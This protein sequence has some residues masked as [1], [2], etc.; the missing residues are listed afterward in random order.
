MIGKGGFGKVWK[1]KFKKIKKLF[2]LK[3]M[4][5]V[6]IIDRRSEISIIN[7]RNFL[8]KLN[9]PFIVNMYFAF[10]DFSNLYLVMDLLTGGDLRYQIVRH[11]TFNEIQ[12]KFFLANIILGLEYIHSKNIIHRDIK[13]EN[14]VMES[15]GYIRITDFGVAKIN[16]KD[17]SS[18]TSGTPGYMAPEVLFVQNHSFPCDFFAIGVIGFEFMLGVRPYLGR[19]RQEI[20]EVVFNFQA[21]IYDEDIPEN[22]S[23][24]SVDFIN[25]L[26]LRKPNKRL[27]Y[28]NGVNELKNHNWFK[29]IDWE[30]LEKKEVE[31]PFLPDKNSENFDKEYCEEIDNV[32]EETIERYRQYIADELFPDVFKGYTFCNSN[33][34]EQLLMERHKQFKI[35]NKNIKKEYISKT[36]FINNSSSN[37]N[38]SHSN[39]IN[40]ENIFKNY[41]NIK[42]HKNLSNSPSNIRK[43]N[44]LNI[45]INNNNNL[46]KNKN[47][48]KSERNLQSKKNI[49]KE[50]ALSYNKINKNIYNNN[51]NNNNNIQYKLELNKKIKKSSSLKE[52]K[53][54][55]LLNKNLTTIKNKNNIN[56]N[57]TI[58]KP[59]IIEINI[60]NIKKGQQL[61]EELM[62]KPNKIKNKKINNFKKLT[63]IQNEKTIIENRFNK[64]E[65]MKIEKKLFDNNNN[66]SKKNNTNT[67]N[68]Y[69]NLKLYNSNSQINFTSKIMSWI[70]QSSAKSRSLS[71]EKNNV[72]STSSLENIS[73]SKASNLYNNTHSK[74]NK[75]INTNSNEENYKRKKKHKNIV[76]SPTNI[77]KKNNNFNNN[78][79]NIDYIKYI[80]N[81]TNVN[82]KKSHI[83]YFHNDS[84][85]FSNNKLNNN[86]VINKSSSTNNLNLKKK[87]SNDLKINV[88]F[89]NIK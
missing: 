64:D 2:A 21:K 6:K 72:K 24:E 43:Y 52:I 62:K 87:N 88:L 20:K 59:S 30:K 5:K 33:I 22:W 25:K 82:K 67:N 53:T 10:Q 29:D 46:V 81:N 16:M 56:N 79:K 31:A 47:I 45:E 76:F 63:Y 1:V 75:I 34:E 51:K 44:K 60:N 65:P 89:K 19:S 3:E 36:H 11:K 57:L 12:T 38:N 78:I 7:E 35:K 39:N 9:N 71:K 69:K 26:L 14:L 58:K 18:E 40:F 50:R 80:N 41:D 86:G 13:P 32:S 68:N 48:N 8:S 49:Y 73:T 55:N 15:T 17:N 42:S 85:S 66:I 61:K 37:F 28:K 77:I 83:F 84:M 4:S 74:S 23:K 54:K 70:Q 27:G